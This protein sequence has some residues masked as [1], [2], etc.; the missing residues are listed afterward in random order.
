MCEIERRKSGVCGAGL[1]LD[2]HGWHV[3]VGEI[4]RV[5]EGGSESC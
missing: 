4:L 3:L 2:I 5:G 1:D